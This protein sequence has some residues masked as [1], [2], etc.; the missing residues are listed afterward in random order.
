[1][2]DL[3]VA[4]LASAIR[5]QQHLLSLVQLVAQHNALFACLDSV[6]A[7]NS[8]FS[9]ACEELSTCLLK[10]LK[11]LSYYELCGEVQS[12]S[13]GVTMASRSLNDLLKRFG[14]QTKPEQSPPRGRRIDEPHTPSTSVSLPPEF[15][16]PSPS[17]TLS[18]KYSPDDDESSD[19]SLV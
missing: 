13:Q 12:L 2:V 8:T 17:P 1:M 14:A 19:G 16:L 18:E 6:A 4:I 7:G 3:V 9:L 11:E 5:V 15:F 10:V